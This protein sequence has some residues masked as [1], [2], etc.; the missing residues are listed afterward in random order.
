MG[1][2][3]QRCSVSG[4]VSGGTKVPTAALPSNDLI[5]L[6]V[7]GSEAFQGERAPAF[8]YV[9]TVA[10]HAGEDFERALLG[11]ILRC[12]GPFQPHLLIDGKA[13]LVAEEPNHCPSC[14]QL[15]Q[16]PRSTRP[17]P[18]HPITMGLMMRE[19]HDATLIRRIAEHHIPQPNHDLLWLR[20][21]RHIEILLRIEEVRS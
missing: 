3:L 2:I 15:V 14:K 21:V 18:L 17:N 11:D 4:R 12:G 8:H 1:Y 19:D 7:P 9:P 13:V 16:L 20:G 6:V 10:D 5:E